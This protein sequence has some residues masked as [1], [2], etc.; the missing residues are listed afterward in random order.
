MVWIYCIGVVVLLGGAAGFWLLCVGT[1]C[2]INKRRLGRWGGLWL[3]ASVLWA[4]GLVLMLK[5]GG[6]GPQQDLSV[7]SPFSRTPA[8]LTADFVDL[9]WLLLALCGSLLLLSFLAKYLAECW[10]GRKRRWTEGGEASVVGAEAVTPDVPPPAG[11]MWR[12]VRRS[13]LIG[14][15]ALSLAVILLLAHTRWRMWPEPAG[16]AILH[17][18]AP[19]QAVCVP[20]TLDGG[21]ILVRA[22]LDGRVTKCL[23]DTGTTDI[24]IPNGAGVRAVDTGETVHVENV[25]GSD[26]RYRRTVLR[27]LHLGNYELRGTYADVEATRDK[28]D[29]SADP[30]TLGDAAF[31]HIVLTI[32]YARR[33]LVLRQPQYDF[34]RDRNAHHGFV[35]S[36]NRDMDDPDFPFVLGTLCGK[37]AKL[38][39]DT[40]NDGDVVGLTERAGAEAT[41]EYS[42][43]LVGHRRVRQKSRH[44]SLNDVVFFL[45]A[46]LGREHGHIWYKSPAEVFPGLGGSRADVG[47]DI[48]EGFLSQFRVTIDYPRRRVLLEPNAKS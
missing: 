29:A 20:F 33:E 34:T 38:I 8:T 21:D 1:Y 30:P 35:M 43:H 45:P 11:T 3:A 10:A 27:H 25:D 40:G 36:I 17:S 15:A 47:V 4:G 13:R 23:V 24:M 5:R 6:D 12:L 44:P 19:Y 14:M 39:L 48:G 42:T 2:L 9:F 18:H 32:D 16:Q 46:T 28:S 41:V 22:S 31:S 7:T 26:D 37:P